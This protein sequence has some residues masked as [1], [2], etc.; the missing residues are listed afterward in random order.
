MSVPGF[1]LGH[2]PHRVMVPKG[3]FACQHGHFSAVLS[4]NKIPGQ[5]ESWAR[6]TAYTVSRLNSSIDDQSCG[7]APDSIS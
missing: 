6:P 7:L 2:L 5:L 3:L 4:K 1:N